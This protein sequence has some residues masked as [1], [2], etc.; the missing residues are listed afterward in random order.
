M[1]KNYFEITVFALLGQ[2]FSTRTADEMCRSGTGRW[3]CFLPFI[4]WTC[5]FMPGPFNVMQA[6]A[7]SRLFL[8]SF[9][10][11]L[12]LSLAGKLYF[13]SFHHFS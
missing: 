6:V 10:G 5:T 7:G 11:T 12:V 2:K 3:F 13:I 4:S 1:L 8:N 9:T